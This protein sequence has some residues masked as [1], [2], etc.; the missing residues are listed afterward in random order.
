MLWY[1]MYV[2]RTSL[3]PILCLFHPKDKARP[4]KPGH[5]RGH[6]FGWG[7]PTGRNPR[8]WRLGEQKTQ[9]EK[10]AKAKGWEAVLKQK[11]HCLF[12]LLFCSPPTVC[13]CEH[14]KHQNIWWCIN[15]WLVLEGGAVFQC[16]NQSGQWQSK[17]PRLALLPKFVGSFQ[18]SKL[19]LY[20]NVLR[21]FFGSQHKNWGTIF[22]STWVLLFRHSQAYFLGVANKLCFTVGKYIYLFLMKGPRVEPSRSRF[23]PFFQAFRQGAQCI[24][25][26]H[27]RWAEEFQRVLEAELFF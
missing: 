26:S 22:S 20:C 10:C 16:D 24:S 12:L 21:C 13:W 19:V 1:V 14:H 2:P 9:T 17:M 27:F 25:I 8:E 15:H 7:V 23:P 11:K 18:C 3:S 4:A 5:G 6:D